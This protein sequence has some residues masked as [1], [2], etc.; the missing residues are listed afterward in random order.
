MLTV[1]RTVALFLVAAVCEIGGAYLIWQWLRSGRPAIFALLG[2]ASLFLYSAV[3]TAQS[4]TFGHAFAAY[5][6][7]FILTAMLWGW[8][9]DGR[10]RPLGLDRG[11]HLPARRGRDALDAAPLILFVRRS[12]VSPCGAKRRNDE[13]NNSEVPCCRRLEST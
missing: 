2:V 13:Q 4:L 10:A 5:G 12:F 9:I 11:R 8:W 6:G 7:V 1:V 3:Q